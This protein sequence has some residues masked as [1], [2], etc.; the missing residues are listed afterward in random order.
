MASLLPAVHGGAPILAMSGGGMNGGGMSG[1]S[2][3]P[4][5]PPVNIAAMSGGA[6]LLPV[7]PYVSIPGMHGGAD[8]YAIP[9]GRVYPAIS[10]SSFGVTKTFTADK[11]VPENPSC[12][13]ITETATPLCSILQPFVD[14]RVQALLK[15]VRFPSGPTKMDMGCGT[16]ERKGTQ[17]TISFHEKAITLLSCDLTGTFAKF[18]EGLRRLPSPV[19]NSGVKGTHGLL[20]WMLGSPVKEEGTFDLIAFMDRMKEGGPSI[21]PLK[22]FRRFLSYHKEKVEDMDVLRYA[23]EL[24]GYRT[25]AIANTNVY[26]LIL[27]PDTAVRRMD[28]MG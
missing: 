28:R 22:G 12:A 18:H 15:R 10:A 19:K 16:I 25:G 5:A 20:S 6:S 24:Y 26:G 8:L 4:A 14:R 3:L 13:P 27:S 17:L 1:A 23:M 7:A 2:M 11:D 21:L 9:H